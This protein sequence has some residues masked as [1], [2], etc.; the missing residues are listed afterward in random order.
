MRACT[1]FE[2]RLAG[3]LRGDPRRCNVSFQL[4]VGDERLS[5]GG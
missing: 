1:L 3:L 2:N 4:G 5:A